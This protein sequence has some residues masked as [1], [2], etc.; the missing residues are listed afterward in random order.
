MTEEVTMDTQQPQGA[1]PAPAAPPE[2]AD[3][4]D[5]AAKAASGGEVGREMLEHAA[6]GAEL[7]LEEEKNA[8][9]WLLGDPIAIPHSIPVDFETPDG[10]KKLE[11]IVRKMDASKIDAI[12][13]RHLNTNTGRMDQAAADCEI[14]GTLAD[15]V[16]T[17]GDAREVDLTSAE[18]RTLRLRN[19]SNGNVETV[20]LAT[21]M[22]ALSARFRG[23][24]GLIMGIAREMRRL[25]GYDPGRVGQAQRRLTE[26]S[27]G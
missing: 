25:A 22:E 8:L 7:S 24:E 23:Q 5:V 11:F 14:V 19:K 2:N 18:F 10:T 26:A 1:P 12:E 27:L 6:Q 13:Q 3:P 4:R 9:D 20:T 16:T 21:P 15:A 17:Q